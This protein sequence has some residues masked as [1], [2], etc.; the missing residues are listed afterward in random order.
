[1]TEVQD[2][3]GVHLLT[4][5]DNLTSAYFT[6]TD[7]SS[8]LKNSGFMKDTYNATKVRSRNFND[9]VLLGG[10]RTGPAIFFF[11]I[12]LEKYLTPSCYQNTIHKKN[13]SVLLC[14]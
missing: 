5:L 13:A 6:I 10:G 7:I 2:S 1:M 3:E 9:K 14:N 8:H 11:R 12:F 4:T